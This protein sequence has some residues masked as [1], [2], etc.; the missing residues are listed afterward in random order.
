MNR[1]NRLLLSLALTLAASP[2]TVRAQSPTA[3][4]IL[5]CVSKMTGVSRIVPSSANC[6]ANEALVTWNH[7]G[8]QGM[9]GAAGPSGPAGPQGPS[10]PTGP[11]GPSGP[12]FLTGNI[13]ITGVA[14][15][16]F[17]SLS[18]ISAGSGTF[19]TSTVARMSQKLPSSCN[20]GALTTTIIAASGPSFV[21]ALLVYVGNADGSADPSGS[22]MLTA[23]QCTMNLASGQKTA[24]CTQTATLNPSAA[25]AVYLDLEGEY[26]NFQNA[27]VLTTFTCQP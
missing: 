15:Y 27:S 19:A 21:N 17:G 20:T 2:L 23:G 18:G 14:T 26:T 6:T 8:P 1:T 24:S 9:T 5:A 22:V 4:V 3:T 10:G 16:M 11:Q 25:Y 13:Q 7:Q 12:Y